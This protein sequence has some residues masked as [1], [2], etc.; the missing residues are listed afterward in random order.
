[1]NVSK[2]QCKGLKT[3]QYQPKL[4]VMPNMVLSNQIKRFSIL[5][6]IDQ[7]LSL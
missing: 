6:Q 4:K 1:M 2:Y 3:R 5:V 7:I